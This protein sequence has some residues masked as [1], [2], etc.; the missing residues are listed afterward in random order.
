MNGEPE[1]E[2]KWHSGDSLQFVRGWVNTA[3]S[4]SR[5]DAGYAE[6]NDRQ[7]LIDALVG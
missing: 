5:S 2:V 4:E 6:Y 3:D 7:V 1:D